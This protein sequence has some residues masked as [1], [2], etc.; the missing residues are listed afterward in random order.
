MSVC[1][2]ISANVEWRAACELL[3]P[4]DVRP[5]PCGE[6]FWHDIAIHG[7]AEATLFFHGGWGKIA[8]AA[9]A[10]YVI[11]HWA[12]A[13]LVN[14]GTCGG[15]R[16]LIERG[17]VVLVE[18]TVVY[19][20]VEQMGDPDEAIAYFSTALDLAWLREPYPHAA[21]RTALVSADRDIIAADIP[22]LARKYGAVAADWETGAIA[23]VAARNGT[24]CLILRGVSDLVDG[25]GGDAYD[26]NAQVF[27]DGARAVMAKLVEAL[28]AWL[29]CATSS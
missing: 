5:S 4:A 23:W 28:P 24:R 1:V 18:R 19:D 3:S 21:R 27:A 16:G 20:I 10:Q 13:L 11:D 6:W 26:G 14:L 7:Q 12:P 17:E 9:S 2:L 22:L 25:A 8:A 29:D 15:F